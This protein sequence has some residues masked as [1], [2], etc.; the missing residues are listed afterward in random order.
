[1]K[2]KNMEIKEKIRCELHRVVLRRGED[3]Y[4]A[5]LRPDRLTG[6]VLC[7]LHSGVIR[8]IARAAGYDRVIWSGHEQDDGTLE[9]VFRRS[10]KEEDNDGYLQDR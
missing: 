9:A 10:T 5:D 2:G 8:S 3:Y 7:G 1:M 4:A 6:G